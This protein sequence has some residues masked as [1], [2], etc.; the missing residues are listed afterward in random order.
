MVE[1]ESIELYIE[2]QI[3]ECIVNS[4][5]SKFD[6]D[7]N[8]F[9]N[10]LNFKPHEVAAVLYKCF[11]YYNVDLY[12]KIELEDLTIIKIAKLIRD[13]LSQKTNI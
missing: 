12:D 7:K 13:E 8:F 2:K 4:L 1:L 5:M 3:K 11:S 6:W 10:E 9:G